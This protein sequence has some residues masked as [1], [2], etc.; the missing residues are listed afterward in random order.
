M[1]VKQLY[2]LSADGLY[3]GDTYFST[4]WEDAALANGQLV[5]LA[6]DAATGVMEVIAFAL[7]DAA[8]LSQ[9]TVPKPPRSD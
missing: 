1:R 9:L 2:W 3:L 7:E 8:R 4:G 5:V 6:P